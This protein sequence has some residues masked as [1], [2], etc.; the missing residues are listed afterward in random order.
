MSQP[1]QIVILGAG[2]A[3]LMTAQRLAHLTNSRQAHITLI[4]ASDR[5]VERIRLHQI[6]NHQPIWSHS[7]I[8]LLNRKRIT[9]IQAEVT[10]I[11]AA[12]KQIQIKPSGN[13]QTLE[14]ETRHYD[15]LVYALGSL[16]SGASVPNAAE[17]AYTLNG[18]S[19]ARLQAV[20]PTI[21][22]Q[23]GK[24]IVVGGGL[25]GI[26]IATE[27]AETYPT[28]S[29]ELIT[30]SVLGADL[31]AK[32][33]EALYNHFK[34]AGI[35]VREGARV[36]RV[37]QHQVV[38]AAGEIIPCT[39]VIWSAG[40]SILP[41]AKEAGIAVNN[42]G[43][44][45]TDAMLRSVSHPDIYG[46]GDAAVTLLSSGDPQR[47]ACATA[48]P[49]G[50]HAAANIAAR[51]KGEALHP[52]RFGYAARCISL[53]RHAGL[54]QAVNAEDRPIDR[55]VTGRPGAFVKELICRYILFTLR[56]ER[57]ISPFYWWPQ[58]RLKNVQHSAGS[59]PNDA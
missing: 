13:M 55:V 41:L 16:T 26:E 9:F 52:F 38:L 15:T 47:M 19:V 45:R 10:A 20:L 53:G 2:Y 18:N 49:M 50:A 46:V 17:V 4:N 40:F 21:A 58:P 22:E 44:L 36:V 54:V 57:F 7:I 42:I 28:L 6:A 56:V 59:L 24:I 1:Q 3:G 31:S 14:P 37:E 32:G 35:T 5:F 43:Q 39:A 30:Q 11:N 25:T 48:V 33:Q 12:Q 29:V 23:H 8:G 27:L 34:K 51:L